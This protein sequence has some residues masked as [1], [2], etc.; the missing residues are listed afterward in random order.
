M[1]DVDHQSSHF[2]VT[3][4]PYYILSSFPSLSTSTHFPSSEHRNFLK[5]STIINH[6]TIKLLWRFSGMTHN[7]KM[8]HIIRYKVPKRLSII[9]PRPISLLGFKTPVM[10][11]LVAGSGATQPPIKWVPDALSPGIKRA[12]SEA[13]HSPPTSADK[14]KTNSVV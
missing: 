7:N 14:I 12:G 9:F 13:D 4:I 8:L 5:L 2:N 1:P 11:I 3:P 6:E 10:I